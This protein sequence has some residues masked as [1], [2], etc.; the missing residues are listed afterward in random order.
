M[1]NKWDFPASGPE[2]NAAHKALT[3]WSETEEGKAAIA[4]V[5]GVHKST[6]LCVAFLAAW[7]QATS[8]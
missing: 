8:R 4:A 1:E 3:A 2:V 6:P 5:G 7:K